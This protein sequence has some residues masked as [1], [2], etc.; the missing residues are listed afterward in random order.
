MVIIFLY[1]KNKN[2]DNRIIKK[3]ME[4]RIIKNGISI[5]ASSSTVAKNRILKILTVLSKGS[6]HRFKSDCELNGI[7]VI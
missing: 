1:Q 4:A 6:P 3:V 2:I 7:V 5:K